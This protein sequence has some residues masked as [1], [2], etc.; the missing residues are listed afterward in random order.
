M[1]RRHVL[2]NIAEPLLVLGSVAFS[3]SLKALSGLSFLG[4]GIQPPQYDWGQMLASGLQDL[5]TNPAVVVAPA[6]AIVLA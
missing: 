3:V 6:V 5:Y 2:P 1:L 4:L